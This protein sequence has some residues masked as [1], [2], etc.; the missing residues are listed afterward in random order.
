[1]IS[2]IAQ[3]LAILL[4]AVTG[5]AACARFTARIHDVTTDTEDPP[6]FVDVVPLRT[7]ARNSAT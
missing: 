4:V 6:V 2:R 7:G 5:S 3:R 1:V